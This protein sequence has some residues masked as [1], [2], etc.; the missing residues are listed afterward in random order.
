[1]FE[2][3]TIVSE[4]EEKEWS[5]FQCLFLAT[6]S[7]VR[8]LRDLVHWKSVDLRISNHLACAVRVRSDYASPQM[9]LQT[10]DWLAY[11]RLC[12]SRLWKKERQTYWHYLAHRSTI[13]MHMVDLTQETSAYDDDFLSAIRVK[14]RYTLDKS[15]TITGKSKRGKQPPL[16]IITLRTKFKLT[17]CCMSLKCWRKPAYHTDTVAFW[18]P[19]FSKMFK[20]KNSTKMANTVQW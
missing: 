12:R 8:E 15:L 19:A 13:I 10:W 1:M 16:C 5:F 14:A 11:M 3:F 4:R 2:R 18:L 9:L 6:Q 20:Q 17:L 7:A